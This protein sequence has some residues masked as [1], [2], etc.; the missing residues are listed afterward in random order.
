METIEENLEEKKGKGRPKEDIYEKYVEGKEE[1]VVMWCRNGADNGVLAKKLGCGKTTISKLIKNY[2]EFKKLI[3]ESKEDADFKVEAALYRKAL[4]YE[5]E[6][7]TTEVVVNKDGSGT[8]TVVKKTKK[9]IS[10]DTTAQIFWLK[11]RKQE[12]WKDRQEVNMSVT[13]FEQMM[14]AATSEDG[15][16]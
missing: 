9:H 7:V 5:Y 16:K 2:P 12:D 8:T 10:G 3:K 14:Q 15:D 4:G 6:E 13:T 1:A 11:N